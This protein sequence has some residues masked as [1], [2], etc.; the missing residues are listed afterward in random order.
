MHQPIELP[1]P[2]CSLILRSYRYFPSHFASAA[3]QPCTGNYLARLGGCEVHEDAMAALPDSSAVVLER[4]DFDLRR[5]RLT[6][7]ARQLE[8]DNS[9]IIDEDDQQ[10]LTLLRRMG[11]AMV[12]RS[13][14]HQIVYQADNLACPRV[15][16]RT[17]PG[18]LCIV[19]LGHTL[20]HLRASKLS[21][22]PEHER[23]AGGNEAARG[24]ALAGGL[25]GRAQR[26]LDPV[27]AVLEQADVE[28]L[29]AR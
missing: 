23:G 6:H 15:A 28:P 9:A 16:F 7:V 20:W 13:G 18:R 14:R 21:V 27:A 4:P 26:Q 5:R 22:R 11:Q 1:H 3:S 2:S 19:P 24:E 10:I 12:D 8:T 17:H 29:Q 25:V